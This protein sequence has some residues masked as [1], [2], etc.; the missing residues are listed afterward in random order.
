MFDL[1]EDFENF[2]KKYDIIGVEERHIFDR[3]RIP[4]CRKRVED[5]SKG[6]SSLDKSLCDEMDEL[7]RLTRDVN[8]FYDMCP[9]YHSKTMMNLNSFF[10]VKYCPH[11]EYGA[12]L[13]MCVVNEDSEK[14]VGTG[15]KLL[16]NFHTEHLN[17]YGAR[18]L[19]RMEPKVRIYLMDLYD[20]YR[21]ASA[22]VRLVESAG[23]TDCTAKLDDLKEAEK[24]AEEVFLKALKIAYRSADEGCRNQRTFTEEEYEAA[25]EEYQYQERK[26]LGEPV[27]YHN[28]RCC[29]EGYVASYG[30]IPGAFPGLDMYTGTEGEL[31]DPQQFAQWLAKKKIERRMSNLPPVGFFGHPVCGIR[32]ADIFRFCAQR[33]NCTGSATM[34]LYLNGPQFHFRAWH[35]R[36]VTMV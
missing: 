31:V 20:R 19:N 2:L 1:K 4:E 6:I 10:D 26:R 21:A 18:N 28:G 3:E 16:F 9:A 29:F 23:E 33:L 15:T 36:W 22:Q 8:D 27:I 35:P 12:C 17:S 7:N 5:L 14:V 13:Y 32:A 24:A 25:Y 34:R 11:M 30:Y